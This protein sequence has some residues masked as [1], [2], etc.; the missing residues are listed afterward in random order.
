MKL[1]LELKALLRVNTNTEVKRIEAFDTPFST[2]A[3]KEY[4]LCYRNEKPAKQ[5]SFDFAES[6]EPPAPVPEASF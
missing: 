6:Q 4:E 3:P 2:H 5:N 1:P